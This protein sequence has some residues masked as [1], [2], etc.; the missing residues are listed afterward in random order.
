MKSSGG[1]GVARKG[2]YLRIHCLEDEIA[3]GVYAGGDGGGGGTWEK[4]YEFEKTSQVIRC[5]R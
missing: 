5:Q 2:I 4:N 3:G 1:V